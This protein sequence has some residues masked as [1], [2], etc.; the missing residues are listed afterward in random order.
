MDIVVDN[1]INY[2]KK[3]K[4]AYL[5]N[6]NIN[7]NEFKIGYDVSTFTF[8]FKYKEN[9]I[10]IYEEVIINISPHELIMFLYYNSFFDIYVEIPQ[11]I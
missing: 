6:Y 10:S 5:K 1:M 7:L 3:T 2:I 4:Q 8:I 11:E 9:K